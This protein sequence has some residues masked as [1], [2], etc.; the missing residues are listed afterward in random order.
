MASLISGGFRKPLAGR[1]RWSEYNL[2][3]RAAISAEIIPPPILHVVNLVKRSRPSDATLLYGELTQNL[4]VLDPYI[5]IT[6][7]NETACLGI[8]DG[9]AIIA[10]ATIN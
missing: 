1:A 8:W 4:D 9:N 6:W 2:D 3:D 5:V 7:N 10:C